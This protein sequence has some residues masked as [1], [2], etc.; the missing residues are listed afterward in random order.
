MS[1]PKGSAKGPPANVPAKSWVGDARVG[2]HRSILIFLFAAYGFLLAATIAIFFLQGFHAWGF[3]L[4]TSLLKWLGAAT[5]GEIG[6]LLYIT[7]KASLI[8]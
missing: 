1:P 7:F 4:E 5:I 6:G 2:F 3:S 8:R